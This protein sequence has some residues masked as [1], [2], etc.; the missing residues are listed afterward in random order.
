MFGSIVWFSFCSPSLSM[1]SL[2]WTRI[3]AGGSGSKV[4]FILSEWSTIGIKSRYLVGSVR[5][6]SAADWTNAVGRH[7][8]NL[9]TF[10]DLWIGR[11]SAFLSASSWAIAFT[12]HL[13][14]LLIKAT[15]LL[16]LSFERFAERSMLLNRIFPGA[17]CTSSRLNASCEMGVLFGWIIILMYFA[18]CSIC[19][20][21]WR[22]A[23]FLG[24]RFDEPIFKRR[25]T[26]ERNTKV[27]PLPGMF[28]I[29]GERQ[30]CIWSLGGIGRLWRRMISR[31]LSRSAE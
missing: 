8:Q 12:D 23:V 16:F 1:A 11:F 13:G 19:S 18:S 24:F 20:I 28:R 3:R 10:G 30:D 26:L 5:N 6:R 21:L 4:Y 31:S 29:W 7:G 15:R 2:S 27:C 14:Q 25:I 22:A 17:N 9:M